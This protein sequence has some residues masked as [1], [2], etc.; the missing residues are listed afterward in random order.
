MREP[1]ALGFFAQ[2]KICQDNNQQVRIDTWG[3]LGHLVLN[4][5]LSEDITTIH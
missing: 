5:L 1:I 4:L 2:I 3:H